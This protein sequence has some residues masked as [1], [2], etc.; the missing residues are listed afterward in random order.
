[1]KKSLFSVLLPDEIQ[2]LFLR[3]CLLPDRPGREAWEGWKE[4]IGD[5]RG[6]FFRERQ[7]IKRLLPLLHRNLIRAEAVVEQNFLSTLETACMREEIQSETFRHV[8]REVFT[9]LTTAN[10]DFLVLKGTV[11]AETVYKSQI[12]R[13]CRDVDLFLNRQDQSLAVQALKDSTFGST[14]NLLNG[15]GAGTVE[16]ELNS[17]FSVHLHVVLFSA[18]YYVSPMPDLWKRSH[19]REIAGVPVRVMA[20]EDMTLHVCGHAANSSSRDTLRWACDAW[21]LIQNTSNFHWDMFLETALQSRLALPLGIL[22]GYLAEELATPVP[23]DV[24][25]EF[26]K[27][28]GRMEKFGVETALSCARLGRRGTYRN[29]FRDA[30][31]WGSRIML[32]RWMF[33]PSFNYL[34]WK[35]T[36]RR[37]W[38]FPFY[39]FYRLFRYLAEFVSRARQLET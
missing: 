7:G 14:A 31:G 13:P 34:H 19:I 24:L 12:L 22:L 33:F 23:G 25:K 32:M 4:S 26:E 27:E 20:P 6:F 2:T 36:P 1:M 5:Y 8:C 30:G 39:Y 10:V 11:L 9:L 18:P 38:H 17:G 28:A 21:Y 37:A 15:S 3:A 16:V 29:L 35:Y